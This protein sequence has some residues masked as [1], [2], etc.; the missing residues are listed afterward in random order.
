MERKTK[1]NLA[2][3]L[4]L[5]LILSYLIFQNIILVLTG[6]TISLYL[7]N[8]NLI[9]NFSK[10]ISTMLARARKVSEAKEN[11]NV[12]IINS[13]QIKLAEENSNPTLVETI[14]EL[15]FIPSIKNKDNSNAA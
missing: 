1:T 4:S 7:L 2:E 8:K 13:N 12:K 5:T 6:I 10:S 9:D 14:E 3:Y 11:D 15:G